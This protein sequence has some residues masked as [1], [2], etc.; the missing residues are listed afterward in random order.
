[1]EKGCLGIKTLD[2]ND[3][4]YKGDLNDQNHH[5]G[6]EWIW[7][8]G[9][10]LKAKLIFSHYES[11]DQATEDIFTY[12]QPHKTHLLSYSNKYEGLPDLTNAH[13]NLCPDAI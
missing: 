2:P 7:P 11:K 5:Q 9:F 12:L 6:P 10:F 4:N 3:Y 1:M 13:G 8:V